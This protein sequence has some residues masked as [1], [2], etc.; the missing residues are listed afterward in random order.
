MFHKISTQDLRIGMYVVDTDVSWLKHPFLYSV[1][2][3][4][5]A[6]LELVRI[7]EQGF[8]EA[9]ID[10]V[11]C[12]PGSL[13]PDLA[14]L[15]LP[16]QEP[17]PLAEY[18]PPPPRVP[19]AE[20]MRAARS[21]YRSSLSQ[22]K[23]MMDNMRKGVFDMP[24][25]EPIVDGIL[26]SL[27]RNADALVGLCKLRQT[28][29]YTY[30]H[31]V[32]VSVL[33][34]MLAR[35]LGAT[36]DK[37]HAIGMGGL[38]HDLGKARIPL[39]V[40]NA[41]RKLSDEELAIMRRHPELGYDQLSGVSGVPSEVLQ[42]VL[43][44]HEKHNGQ[45]YPRN[46]ADKEISFAGQVSSL[47]D[48]FDALSSKRVYKEALPLSKALSIMY[49]MRD[50]D[51]DGGMLERFIRLMGVYPVGSV[52]ELE[53]G[54]FAVVSASNPALPLRPVVIPVKDKE[55]AELERKEYDLSKEGAPAIIR[56]ASSRELGADPG[57]V[58]GLPQRI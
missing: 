28:D 26:E 39:R 52:V 13:P 22:A 12:K 27:D 18:R 30:T 33:T 2:G 43:E 32:N 58:L 56:T 50:K 10:L 53:D 48:V 41:P 31:C 15:V 40:L 45:G 1:E 37:L 55:G 51:F 49:S 11:R 44:H 29:D 42:I 34:V 3:E 6:P 5:T 21:I 57:T 7:R 54:S 24:V 9:F 23:E 14:N 47:V 17:V 20:E 36:G 19:L 25:A 35:G 16:G 38:F 8:L 46:L 4:I